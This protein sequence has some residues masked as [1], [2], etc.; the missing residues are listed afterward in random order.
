MPLIHSVL[1]M[2]SFHEGH[3]CIIGLMMLHEGLKRKDSKTKP[4]A[5]HQDST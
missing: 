1:G 3:H 5:G 2:K 4:R